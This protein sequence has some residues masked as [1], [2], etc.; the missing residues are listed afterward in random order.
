ARAA[1]ARNRDRAFRRRRGGR[2]LP[3]GAAR[4]RLRCTESGFEPDRGLAQD[5]RP[6]SLCDRAENERR[7]ERCARRKHGGK[8]HH[9]DVGNRP[10]R[11]PLSA[12]ASREGFTPTAPD[13]D[14]SVLSLPPHCR[15]CPGNP[16]STAVEGEA[17]WVRGSSPRMTSQKSSAY[18]N[19]RLCS[20]S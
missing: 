18:T 16:C 3:G 19:G 6:F 20:I 5:P 9:A 12:R 15:A 10:I 17:A 4:T 14:S 13:D 1:S 2:A 7:E 8:A 11:S